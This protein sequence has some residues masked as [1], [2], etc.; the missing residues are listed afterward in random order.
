MINDYLRGR[1]CIESV[2]GSVEFFYFE[3]FLALLS[4]F[5]WFCRFSWFLLA[6]MVFLLLDDLLEFFLAFWSY[7]CASWGLRIELQTLCL[8]LSID[9]SRGRLRNQV[10]SSLV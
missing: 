5:D 3:L 6:F 8:L 10:A 4:H 2:R 1:A 9:S 7:S